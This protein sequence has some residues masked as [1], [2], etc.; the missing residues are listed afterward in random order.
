MSCKSDILHTHGLWMFPNFYRNPNS[1]FVVSPH[2]MLSEEALK[3]SS[4]KKKI[5][6]FLFQRSAFADAKLLFATAESEFEDIRKYGLKTPV[7]VI[8][9]GVNI[10]KIKKYNDYKNK[11]TIISLGRLH[12]KKGLDTLIKAWSKIELNFKDW[13][14]KIVGPDEVGHKKQL[15]NIVRNLNLQRVSFE[16][17]IYG[18]EKDIL[19][20]KC[21]LFVLPSILKRLF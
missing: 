19:L 17:A 7:A 8:P 15:E 1:I 21:D 4:R 10:P 16:P 13:E 2:G 6:D 3:F 18:L 20:S 9:N 12:P 14:L 5:F 11:K